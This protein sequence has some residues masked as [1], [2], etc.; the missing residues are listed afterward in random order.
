MPSL[1]TTTTQQAEIADPFN[2]NR[3]SSIRAS[4]LLARAH[5]V[6]GQHALSAAALDS[7]LELAQRGQFLTSSLLMV[8]ERAEL[9][10]SGV[11]QHW[12]SEAA[13]RKQLA[14]AAARMQMP[15]AE[16]QALAA[17]LLPA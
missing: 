15:E 7:G 13:G 17:A 1:V 9:A 4:Q 16:Q 5:A 3:L 11:A 14:E 6:T 12:G 8:R 10:A 2:Y